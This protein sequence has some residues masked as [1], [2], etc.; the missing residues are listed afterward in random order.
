[1]SRSRRSQGE[2]AEITA[3]SGILGL[4]NGRIALQEEDTTYYVLGLDRLIGFID[5]LKEG[6]RVALEGYAFTPWEDTDAVLFQV[7]K[8]T[9][10]GKEYDGLTPV[11]DE[12]EQPSRPQ[13]PEFGNRRMLQ[14]NMRNHHRFR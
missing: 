11:P 3:I 9:L 1:M 13:P 7:A 8:L 6:A 10:N 4:S 12:P 5:G 2:K 14:P